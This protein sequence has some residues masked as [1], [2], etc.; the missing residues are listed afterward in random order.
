MTCPRRRGGKLSSP[1]CSLV[2]AD[3]EIAAR[4]QARSRVGPALEALRLGLGLALCRPFP[5]LDLLLVR[6]DL[7]LEL[8]DL[9]LDLRVPIGALLGELGLVLS[10]VGLHGRELL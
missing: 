4:L 5:V 2:P 8:G 6:R 1:R 10:E 7:G 9:G 3:G